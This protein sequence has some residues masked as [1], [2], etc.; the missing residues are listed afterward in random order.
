MTEALDVN[1]L[2]Q[3][4]TPEEQREFDHLLTDGL[5]WVPQPGPQTDAFYS[6]ADILLF[7]GAAGG[8]KTDLLIG[9]ATTQHQDSI[10][11]RRESVQLKGIVKRLTK[12]LGTRDGYNGQDKAWRL[13]TK[14]G[15]NR[16]LDLGHCQHQGDEDKYQGQPHDLVGFDELAHFLKEQFLFLMGWNRNA[17]DPSQRCRVVASTNPPTGEQEEHSE[18]IIEYWGPWLDPDHPNPAAPGELRW[19][20]AIDGEDVPVDDGTPFEHNGET[21]RPK[22]RTFIPSKVQDNV[23]LADS[24][25]VATL[26]ALPEPLRS[27]MLHGDF[28]LA[29]GDNPWQVIPTEWVQIAMDRWTDKSPKGEMDSMGVDVARGGKDNTIISTRHGMWFD[30]L[31]VYPGKETPDGPSVAAQVVNHRRNAAPV[32]VDIIGVGSSVYDTLQ[33]NN[34]HAIPVNV[35]EGT[36]EKD[37]SG[38]LKFRNKRALTWW[39]MREALDPAND[40]GIA[41]PPDKELKV[42]LTTPRWK[43]QGGGVLVE[44]KED[45]RK[46]IQRS[47]DRADA[48]NLALIESLKQEAEAIV[49]ERPVW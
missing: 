36:K 2:Y 44:G 31:H 25:Y 39:R 41:L 34:I 6:E 47:T 27:K 10:I 16:H 43:L 48:V 12:I 29:K 32:H 3:Y 7:G 45:I 18:W 24:S 8:G 9:L 46:R 35:A 40:T 20:A 17:E 23:F 37:L 21:I 14:D 1:E 15:V 19:Y 26:Q 22:S 49:F 28:S 38:V 5:L 33:G 13:P 11:F 30:N 42:E 4:M